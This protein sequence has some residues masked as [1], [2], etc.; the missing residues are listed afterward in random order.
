MRGN[1]LLR[2]ASRALLRK[3]T[4]T[5]R[6]FA[7]VVAAGA[8]SSAVG[9]FAIADLDRFHDQADA[10]LDATS[11]DAGSR[12]EA[13]SPTDSGSARDVAPG[14]ESGA[15]DA[16]GGATF[17]ALDDAQRWSFFD[18]QGVGGFVPYSGVV[19]DGRYLYFVP[20]QAQ[21]NVLRYDTHGDFN[22]TASWTYYAPM[23]ALEAS[24]GAPSGA[25]PYLGGAFDGRYVY[26]APFGTNTYTLQY[27]TQQP[28]A[29]R[30]DPWSA[31][32]ASR[33]STRRRTIGVSPPTGGTRTSFPT[34]RRPSSRTTTRRP[35]MR[36][37][38]S[39]R[40]VRGLP[41]TSRAGPA[42]PRGPPMAGSGVGLSP[43]A[44]LF[45]VPYERQRCIPPRY[46]AASLTASAGWNDG[47][48]GFDFLQ[49]RARIAAPALLVRGL[50]WPAPLPHPVQDAAVDARGVRHVG[51]FR[52]RRQLGDLPACHALLRAAAHRWASWARPS[53]ASVS[54]L[55]A[56]RFTL[57]GWRAA[58]ALPVVAFDTTQPLC[59][60]DMASAYSTF[61]PTTLVG[62]AGA[63][64]FEG[65]AFDGQYV[66]FVP[67]TGSV[68]ARFQA[69]DV[70][71]G[72]TPAGYRGSWG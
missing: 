63:T 29:R 27:D 15:S 31:Y 26:F 52:R 13:G 49:Q 9:C 45:L 38:G 54:F 1:R 17:Y 30:R 61:D 65:A 22:D 67:H 16:S 70:N 32:W 4:P 35:P 69:R 5:H 71:R 19:F 39:R 53:T 21:P 48:N 34:R 66:Y 42:T 47:A 18:V 41:T 12:N 6:I 28:F 37:R 20:N 59:P 64:G 55:A 40:G 72:L 51:K 2:N 44:N 10:S 46:D 23:A 11:T 50:R 33:T 36:V 58:S 56:A 62:G 8:S 3:M 24:G 7:V 25:Y 60:S 57:R 14:S 68:V 43:D